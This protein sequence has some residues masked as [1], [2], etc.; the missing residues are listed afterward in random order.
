MTIALRNAEVAP[1]EI[2]YIVAHGTSTSLN[3]VTETRAIK[4]AFGA[5]AKQ[6]AVSSPKSMVGHLVGAAGIASALAALGGDPGPDVI[7]PTANL[8]DPDPE[9]DLDYVPLVARQTGRHRGRQRL[10]LR[11]PERGGDLPPLRGL[12]TGC[13]P[14]LALRT[15]GEP[16]WGGAIRGVEGYLPPCDRPGRR[17]PRGAAD[18]PCPCDV[19]P[20]PARRSPP[21]GRHRGR[22]PAD[23]A[24][25]REPR[26]ISPAAVR[27]DRG[28]RGRRVRSP[29]RTWS[30]APGAHVAARDAPAVPGVARRRGDRREPRGP[31]TEARVPAAHAGHRAHLR[32]DRL[33]DLRRAHAPRTTLGLAGHRRPRAERVR[34]RH[35]DRGRCARCIPRRRRHPAHPVQ[36]RAPHRGRGGRHRRGRRR[37]SAVPAAGRELPRRGWPRLHGHRGTVRGDG[38]RR[39]RRAPGLGG[40]RARGAVHRRRVTGASAAWHHRGDDASWDRHRPSTAAGPRRGRRR[41]MPPAVAGAELQPSWSNSRPAPSSSRSSSSPSASTSSSWSARSSCGR[42]P[43]AP[44]ASTMRIAL[45][46]A[47]SRI[48]ARR[49]NASPR[50]RPAIARWSSGSPRSS[51]ST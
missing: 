9:C 50:R 33:A 11:R 7:P 14:H 21:M 38:C 19:R 8:H 34:D 30:P 49:P 40:D 31:G 15:L 45:P 46:R 20:L 51:T 18:D 24:D 2:D 6:V 23:V 32:V 48:P 17:A 26:P 37:R 41:D 35:R 39:H 27:A 4:S 42:R 29:R 5:H 25:R 22:R 12:S 13:P 43:R 10:R 28:H 3:D 47:R 16:E 44:T 1:D 36:S